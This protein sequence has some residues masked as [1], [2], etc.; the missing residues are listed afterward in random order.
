MNFT[1]N[2]CLLHNNLQIM[3][4]QSLKKKRVKI[5]IIITKFEINK[6]ITDMIIVQKQ[7]KFE[8]N[9]DYAHK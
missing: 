6:L 7:H 9:T 2:L 8:N 3:I 1:D 5:F 4:S